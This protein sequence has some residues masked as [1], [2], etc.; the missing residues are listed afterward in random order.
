MYVLNDLIREGLL[1]VGE[2]LVWERK[3]AKHTAKVLNNGRI[4]TS[5]GMTH[6]T[7]SGASKHLNDGKSVDGWLMWKTTSNGD[8]LCDLRNELIK[9][10]Q[11]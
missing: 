3:G 5:D 10:R 11:K 4:E 1:K 9:R 7:P 8:K 6:K 2:V